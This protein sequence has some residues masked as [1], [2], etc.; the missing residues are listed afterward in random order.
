MSKGKEPSNLMEYIEL[1][2]KEISDSW[3]NVVRILIDQEYGEI[4]KNI[5]KEEAQ[6]RFEKEPPGSSYGGTECTSFHIYTKDNILF[7][8]Q[9][10]GAEWIEHI[11][12]NFKVEREIS[13]VG[14][15]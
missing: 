6:R 5:T 15:G 1:Y 9:Y 4:G 14:G 13:H 3:D 10:D 2:L 7:M 8:G 12:L 11:P